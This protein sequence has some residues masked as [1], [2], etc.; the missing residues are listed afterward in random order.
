MSDDAAI[1]SQTT[2]QLPSPV[3]GQT[4]VLDTTQG[5]SVT[6]HGFS[7]SGGAAVGSELFCQ[8]VGIGAAL[9]SQKTAKDVMSEAMKAQFYKIFE[10]M[11]DEAKKKGIILINKK[12]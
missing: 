1:S 12:V 2:A 4:Q 5:K 6:S 3:T 11:H 7:G 9:L 8:E 10:S